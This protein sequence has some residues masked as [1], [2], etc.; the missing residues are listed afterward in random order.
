MGRFFAYPDQ[1]FGVTVATVDPIGVGYADIVT[2][3]TG[4]VPLIALYNGLSFQLMGVN[5]QPS[6]AG[7]VNVAGS[8]NR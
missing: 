4:N 6:G 1:S 2:G 7:G 3:F 5:G 8:V